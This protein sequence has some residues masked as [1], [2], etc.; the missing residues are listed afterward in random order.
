[1]ANEYLDCLMAIAAKGGKIAM[2]LLDDSKPSFKTDLSILTKADLA[3]SALA[4]RQLKPYLKT[5]QHI[6]ID[7]EDK[8]HNNYF[9]QSL[10]ESKRYIWVIDPID[11]TRNFANRLPT[12]GISIGLLK[13]LKPWLGVVYFPMLNELFYCDGRQ[14]YFVKNAFSKKEK[15]A[16]I[17][18]VDPQINRQSIF[19]AT[20]SYFKYFEWDYSFC[21]VMVLS[22]AVTDLCWPAIGRGCGNIFRS[23]LWD[24]AGSWPIAQSAGLQLRNFYTGKILDR[25]DTGVFE[26]RGD[27]T[28]KLKDFHILSSERNFS[29]IQNRIKSMTKKLLNGLPAPG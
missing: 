28:W 11:G 1:M 9:D 5:E 22:C 10:L 17:K 7:E 14:S 8:E 23:N 6:L 21:T 2:E 19:F 27:R 25:V 24:F 16:K 29:I 12:W 26:G 3:I 20:D 4:Q 18:P 13:D 15:A